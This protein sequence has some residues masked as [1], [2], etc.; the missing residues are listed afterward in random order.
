MNCQLSSII[1]PP[2]VPELKF[3]IF[4]ILMGKPVGTKKMMTLCTAD[5]YAEHKIP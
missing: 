1:V 4:G 2:I 3:K 5:I